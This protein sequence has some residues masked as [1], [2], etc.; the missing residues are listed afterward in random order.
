MPW[1]LDEAQFHFTLTYFDEISGRDRVLY[2]EFID[3]SARDPD[4][5]HLLMNRKTGEI[6]ELMHDY[7]V[8]LCA[9][10]EAPKP[11]QYT[12]PSW[13]Y[14]YYQPASWLKSRGRKEP[15]AKVD[16]AYPYLV[17]ELLDSTSTARDA[18][19]HDI[20]LSYYQGKALIE[21]LAPIASQ[22]DLPPDVFVL[23]SYAHGLLLARKEQWLSKKDILLNFGFKSDAKVG[24]TIATSDDIINGH[25]WGATVTDSK[26]YR[27]Y[28]TTISAGIGFD[29][30][31][32]L[33]KIL[34]RS[35]YAQLRDQFSPAERLWFYRQG[36]ADSTPYTVYDE[37]LEVM[38]LCSTIAEAVAAI[39]IECEKQAIA[40]DQAHNVPLQMHHKRVGRWL[41]ST[42]HLFSSLHPGQ[43]PQSYDLKAII[44][45]ID[46]L[47][48][49]IHVPEPSDLEFGH[50][51]TLFVQAPKSVRGPW[52]RR[53][54][55]LDR[56]LKR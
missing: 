53:F 24:A 2:G 51:E 49:V 8:L 5:F 46:N 48:R 47:T 15:L 30:V 12:G 29:K 45:H 20:A 55:I 39:A 1:P 19:D 32:R 26:G 27:R 52:W 25:W 42:F 18:V 41:E 34:V 31:R 40:A 13:R 38:R 23:R 43:C 16:Q 11:L 4:Y 50:R 36:M 56:W 54:P 7:R 10:G 9:P 21:F 28:G 35:R 44:G 37:R 3:A 22:D 14:V 33:Y 6:D 17:H